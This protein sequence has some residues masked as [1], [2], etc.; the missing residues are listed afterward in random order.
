MATRMATTDELP[1]NRRGVILDAAARAFS[2]RG[3]AGTSIREI[4]TD[5]GVQP[6]S[7]Y[8]FFRSKDDIY[9]AVYQLG[10]EKILEAVEQSASASNDPWDRLEKAA[11]AHLE[12][13]LEE[14]D[15]NTLV[16]TVAPKEDSSLG[17]RLVR[18]RDRYEALFTA[19]IEG[20]PMPREVDRKLFRLVFLSALNGVPSWYRPSGVSPGK[21]AIETVALFRSQLDITAGVER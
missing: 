9:E 21:I 17:L 8:H 20:L 13:L 15:Y 10:V 7:L 3:Y 12:A 6:S 14:G 5:A 11:I 1:E 2:R 4:A 16:A 18:Y 19:L